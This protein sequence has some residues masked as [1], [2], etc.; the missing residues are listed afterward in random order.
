MVTECNSRQFAY[1]AGPAVEL[2]FLWNRAHHLW[3]P[4]RVLEGLGSCLERCA[5]AKGAAVMG[6]GALVCP[7]VLGPSPLGRSVWLL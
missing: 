6:N 3:C 4:W 5:V 1:R 2:C 7:H